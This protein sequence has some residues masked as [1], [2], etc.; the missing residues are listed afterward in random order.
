M[1][2]SRRSAPSSSTWM[3]YGSPIWGHYDVDMFSRS[4]ESSAVADEEAAVWWELSQR[5]SSGNDGS[6]EE[7]R[8]NQIHHEVDVRKMG[9]AERHDFIERILKE[10]E[11]NEAFLKRLRSRIDRAGIILPTVE[12][13]FE[14]ITVNANCY[15]GSRALP[16]LINEIA[17][18]SESILSF[19]GMRS[20]QMKEIKI[21]R[22]VSG[23]IRPSRMTLLLGPP[24]SGKTT[25]LITLAGK[26]HPSLERK[27]EVT[28]NGYKLNEFVPQKTATYISQNDL[29][30]GEMTVKETLEFSA[31][32][33][34]VGDRYALLSELIR[35]EKAQGIIPNHDVDLFMK[36]TSMEGVQSRFQTEYTMRILGLDICCDTVLG[37][38]MRRGISGGQKK[39]VTTGELIVGP[40]RTL[41]MDDISTGLDSSTTNQVVK[42]LQQVVHLGEATIVMSLLQPAPE[43]FELFDDIILLVEG[44]IVYQGPREGALIFFES[45]GFQCPKRKSVPDFLL[46]V[47]SAKDQEQ[48][49][50]DKCKPYRFI[51]IR[52]FV[53]Y[54]KQSHFSRDLQSGL[55]IPFNKSKSHR[56]ALVFNKCSVP[57]KELLKASFGR[58]WLL[59]KRNSFVYI[60]KLTHVLLIALIYSSV[61][62]R[63]M[64]TVTETDGALH[65]G[66]LLYGLI[67]N[68][69]NSFAEQSLAIM[70]LPVFFKQRD[71]L[72][73]PTWVFTLPNCIIRIPISVLETGVWVF[74]TYYIVGFAP[75]SSRL[76]KQFLIIFLAQQMAAG[77]FRL[78]A[79]LAR[80]M[81]TGNMSTCIIVITLFAVSGFVLP[82]GLL[83]K[84]CMLV[85]WLSPLTYAFNSIVI[86]EMFS[87]R[88][89][90]KFAP[91]GRRL[92][93]AI[94][95]NFDLFTD[96]IWYWKSA[97]VLLAY[98]IFFNILFTLTVKHVHPLS[99]PNSIILEEPEVEIK[100]RSFDLSEGTNLEIKNHFESA[101]TQSGTPDWHSCDGY[102]S[103]TNRTSFGIGLSL[104]FEPLS[105]SFKELNYYV[106][107]PQGQGVT[108]NK[109]QLL[110]G[111][112]GAFRQ[113]ILTALMGESGA[114]KTTLMDVLAGRKTGGQVDGDIWIAG[115]PKKQST[116]A[117]ISGYC[118]QFDIH[119][120][121]L[122]VEESLIFSAMLRLPKEVSREAKFKFVDVVMELVELNILKNALVGVPGVTGL[123]TEQRKRL[124]IAVEL[125]ANP[126]IIFMDEP[127]SGL[128]ARA[129]AIVMRTVRNTVNTGRTVVCTIHQPS[130]DIFE[131]FDELLLLKR[132]GQVI[133]AGPLGQSSQKLIDYFE[134]I[135]G[136]QRIK[137]GSNPAAWMLEVSSVMN[138]ARLGIDFAEIYKSSTFCKRNMALVNEL[139]TPFDGTSDLYFPTKYPQSSFGQ[140]KICLWK[141]WSIHWRYPEYNI[142]RL[143]S[144]LIIALILGSVFWRIGRRRSSSVDLYSVIGAM[145]LSVLFVGFCNCATVQP[146][147]AKERTVYYREKAAGLYSALPYALSQVLVELPYVFF[148]AIYYTF[149]I[150]SMMCFQWT[151]NKFL[152][153]F[154][155][156]FLSLLYFTYYGMLMMAI[157]PNVHAAGIFGTSF[158]YIFHLFSGFFIPRT[159]LPSWWA[160]CFWVCPTSWSFYG[161]IITQY[162]D[163]KDLIKVPGQVEQQIGDYLLNYYGY[164]SDFKGVVMLVIF[165]FTIFFAV[166]YIICIRVLNFHHR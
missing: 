38:E 99:K 4:R 83:P 97:S 66:A 35:R 112:S 82:Q 108:G 50:A 40:T 152:G 17:N 158:F 52:E 28:Y 69:F 122:T 146:F 166:M 107:V 18:A 84:W 98:G 138:E 68:I 43:T 75:E 32:C 71:L 119:S 3:H 61:F 9:L 110:R 14:K 78:V 48:Y 109:I 87:P 20:A 49:W 77:L 47:T 129:A 125:V 73:Y 102:N 96:E 124:T 26:L 54:F 36:A 116:F 24:S 127:T 93:V 64:H 147:V 131:S 15:V 126:S 95:Q 76:F 22:D 67:L 62:L 85:Y 111:V 56:A 128:D 134:S 5:Y 79:G 163:M 88:W 53:E 164:R 21:L 165:G 141:Y 51:P 143:G 30:A 140:L 46:E 136:V 37:D 44:Q 16:T 60:F 135:P 81:T 74:V 27:G 33:Q 94:L 145:Y 142:S 23:I 150:Y 63:K 72:F 105:M 12:V 157:S 161:L 1:E 113:G 132:G 103:V 70:R 100:S 144:T 89:M 151:M 154:I 123:S 159:E 149:I 120:P 86:N 156:S 162:G 59:I 10:E 31:R 25:L 39:R 139:S 106:N 160:W 41:F 91:D 19:L 115:Y 7:G 8:R 133:Y 137:D 80:H 155:I 11:D 55:S 65:I 130:I 114:G 90:E 148:Q 58:E 13:R 29:H 34:G 101:S 117:R 2:V 92:G 121:Q 118:E 6:G 153:F 45:C 42:C 57:L 104:P